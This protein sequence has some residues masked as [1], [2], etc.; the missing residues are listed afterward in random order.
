MLKEMTPLQQRLVISSV[1]IFAALISIFL[2]PIPIFKP[3]FAGI[4]AAIVAVA[5][6]EFYQIS[7]AKGI[8]SNHI[9][10]I[11]LGVLYIAAV[12]LSTQYTA[13]HLLPEMVLLA[14]LI[15][16]F[17]YYCLKEKM[18]F[19]GLSVI[20]LNIVYLVIPLSCIIRVVYFTNP[21]GLQDG[22][23]WLLYLLVITKVTDAGGFFIGKRFGKQ[24]LAPYISPKK[25]WEGAVGGLCLA[26]LSSLLFGFLGTMINSPAFT[27]TIGQ[28]AWLGCSI[29][30]LAQFGDLAESLLKRDAG[31]KDSSH[32]PGLG[33]MLDIVDSLIFTAPL[34]SI[35][36]MS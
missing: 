16:A 28:S 13:A 7:S 6:W 23:W 19:A 15:V 12:T 20:S 21:E 17:L 35:F 1:G 36:L 9:L 34:V 4:V 26:I 25:T 8:I 30:I 5:S 31:V 3:I 10:G 18:P 29:G 14:S 2:S 22:R 33:G 24:L 32:L 27:L 11:F